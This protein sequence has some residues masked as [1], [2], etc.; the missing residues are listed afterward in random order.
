MDIP[1]RPAYENSAH[2]IEEMKKAKLMN[3]SHRATDQVDSEVVNE[4]DERH[5]GSGG[6]KGVLSWLCCVHGVK[7]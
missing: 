5:A 6:L 4:V 3:F 7:T 2:I 1:E